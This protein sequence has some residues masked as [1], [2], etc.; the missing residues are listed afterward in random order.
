MGRKYLGAFRKFQKLFMQAFVEQSGELLRCVFTR[1]IGPA[2]IADKESV[3]GEDSAGLGRVSQIGEHRADAFKGVPRGLEEIEAA[4]SELQRVPVFYGGVRKGRAR[5]SSDIDARARTF[6]KFV[7]PGDEV[8]V[9]VSFDDVLDLQALFGGEIDVKVDVALGVY[10]SR[11]SSGTDQVG[12]V[13][14]A[15]EEELFDRYW[16]YGFC[17]HVRCPLL[18]LSASLSDTGW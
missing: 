12:G 5:R 15:A 7:V 2:H 18:P 9:Q 11:D 13:G 14:E 16:G 6:G 8:G 17:L 10:D 1:E 4:V 3:S